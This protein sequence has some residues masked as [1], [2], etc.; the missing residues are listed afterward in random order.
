MAFYT[1]LKLPPL[2]L[3]VTQHPKATTKVLFRGVDDPVG[4]SILQSSSSGS[5]EGD[6]GVGSSVDPTYSWNSHDG[7]MVDGPTLHELQRKSSVKG[8]EEMRSKFFTAT[9]ECS[10]MPLGQEC[11]FCSEP[12]K[13]RCQECGPQIFFCE[14][15]WL[16]HHNKVNFFHT[17]ERWEV[18]F[19]FRGQADLEIP[20]GGTPHPP[21][22][23]K[24]IP[25]C[26]GKGA[27]MTF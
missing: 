27:L 18:S 11:L 10:A 21:T 5:S 20:I 26:H 25:A 16:S 19:I 4:S 24:A 6:S 2:K 23:F 15:C 17:L 8:W 9:V 3:T 14:S 12:A 22:F 13:F 7:S 1:Q